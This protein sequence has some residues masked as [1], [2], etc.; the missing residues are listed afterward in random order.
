MA[1]RCPSRITSKATGQ[2]LIE[3]TLDTRGVPD[4]AGVHI[5]DSKDI[6]LSYAAILM[7][8]TCHFSPAE[9]DGHKVRSR[10]VSPFNIVTAE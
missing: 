3:F 9:I 4:F 10:R 7:L 2:V 5:T 6:R 8:N 1:A